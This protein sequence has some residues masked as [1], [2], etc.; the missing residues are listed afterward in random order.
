MGERSGDDTG[1]S[2]VCRRSCSP[3]LETVQSREEGRGT[4]GRGGAEHHLGWETYLPSF[5]PSHLEEQTAQPPGDCFA[6]IQAVWRGFMVKDSRTVQIILV[7]PVKVRVL[8]CT[9]PWDSCLH[10]GRVSARIVTPCTSQGS[11]EYRMNT[12]PWCRRKDTWCVL[13][14]GPCQPEESELEWNCPSKF[15]LG[16]A[17][18]SCS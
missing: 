10:W 7:Q 11:L 8:L 17:A 2:W 12:Q 14:V 5:I 13:E 3:A 6:K 9:H 16:T 4:D 18:E 15:R 1:P